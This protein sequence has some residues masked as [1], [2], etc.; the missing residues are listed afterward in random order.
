MD[1]SKRERDKGVIFQI[2]KQLTSFWSHA[3]AAVRDN[4]GTKP[5]KQQ[6][7]PPSASN[8]ITKQHKHPAEMTVALLAQIILLSNKVFH[9]DLQ[10]ASDSDNWI[11]G[12][13]ILILC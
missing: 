3:A 5:T 13:E 4:G 8:Q 6:G 9:T 1:V 12:E 2:I 7:I 10:F 11:T